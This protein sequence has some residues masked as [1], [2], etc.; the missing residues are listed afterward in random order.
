M[1]STIKQLLVSPRGDHLAIVTSHTVHIAIL[2]H[3]ALLTSDDTAPLKIKTFQLGPTSHVVDRSPVASVLWH[4][5]G[6]DGTCLVTITVDAVLRLWELNKSNRW[7]F[8]SPALSFDLKKLADGSTI[9]DDFSPSKYG[10]NKGFSP[11]SFDLEI[12]AA[13]F[14]QTSIRNEKGWSPMTLWL[15]T[16]DG[17][18]YAL[19]PLLPSKWQMPPDFFENVARLVELRAADVETT[20]FSQETIR[21]MSGQQSSWIS[22]LQQQSTSSD[23][24]CGIYRRPAVPG[25]IPKLQGPFQ[26]SSDADVWDVTD[27][28]YVCVSSE[29]EEVDDDLQI[30]SHDTNLG[31]I[32]IA[33]SSGEVHVFLDMDGV[34]GQW[35]PQTPV[36]S[37]LF[38][39]LAF[40]FFANNCSRVI[41]KLRTNHLL[42]MNSCCLR[43]YRWAHHMKVLGQ[44]SL[45]TST[46]NAVS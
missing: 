15:S 10:T 3:S 25:A 40:E 9:T 33:A 5:L 7:S 31:F 36:S 2:P 32:C 22:E 35:L 23:G 6:V 37:C 16:S 21:T 14:G 28:H 38:Q 29:Q 44:C 34:T 30:P 39:C 26:L 45:P 27:I 12:A 4:P 46:R 11:D 42:S 19:C 24:D 17:D 8:D 41:P 18:V 43:A 20:P 13:C 1:S